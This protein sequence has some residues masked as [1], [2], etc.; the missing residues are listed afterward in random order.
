MIFDKLIHLP[1]LIFFPILNKDKETHEN[2]QYNGYYHEKNHEENIKF[3][4]KIFDEINKKDLNNIINNFLKK[5][6]NIYSINIFNEFSEETQNEIKNF[7]NKKNKI[8]KI[9]DMLGYRAKL[10]NVGLIINF[11]NEKTNETGGSK[12]YHRDSDSLNDQV[13]IFML[14][15]DI[16][17]DTGMFYF[18][19][20]FLIND[21][22][23][24]PFEKDR[25]NM[26]IWEKWRNY[27]KTILSAIRLKKPNLDPNLQVKKLEGKAGETLYIDTGKIYHKGGLV[28]NQNN[29]RILL[30]AVYTPILSLSGWNFN[31]KIKI[32]NYL[33]NKLTTLRIKLRKKLVLKD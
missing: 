10:R 13:K 32:I 12:M 8:K 11:F 7:F 19:P 27:D 33:T 30:Q 24:L 3:A 9:S 31:S 4:K 2:F 17:E 15:N 28:S 6:P 20:K 5:N 1:S 14:L 16:D 22:Y 26:N 25:A 18:V 21:D 23:R 29:M